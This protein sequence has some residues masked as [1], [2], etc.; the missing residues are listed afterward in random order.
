MH[1][2]LIINLTDEQ[3]KMFMELAG[4]KKIEARDLQP[5]INWGDVVQTE[6]DPAV[7]TETV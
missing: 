1:H 7:V 5:V 6:L 2:L 4:L 3:L